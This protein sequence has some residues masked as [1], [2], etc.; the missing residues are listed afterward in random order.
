MVI[1][2]Q[3]FCF[4]KQKANFL[5][6]QNFANGSKNRKRDIRQIP[7]CSLCG[8]TLA[9]S[10]QTRL[11]SSRQRGREGKGVVFATILIARSWFN[12]HPGHVV[13]SVDKMLYDDYF[14]LVASNKQ[15]IQWTRIHRNIGS[16]G[17]P[18]SSKQ[19]RIPPTKK[20]SLQ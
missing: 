9:A 10:F 1:S 4:Q 19:V 18:N 14:G 11:K 13:A 8:T 3:E 2:L 6:H 5:T 15:R 16:L 20:W 7:R 17:T 12:P